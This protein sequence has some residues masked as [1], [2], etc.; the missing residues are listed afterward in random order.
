MLNQAGCLVARAKTKTE[1]KYQMLIGIKGDLTR[2][3]YA[4]VRVHVLVLVGL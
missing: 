1:I 4:R 2:E 3:S